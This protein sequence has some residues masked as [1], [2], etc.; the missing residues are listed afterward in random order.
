MS[1]PQ[2]SA[3]RVASSSTCHALVLILGHLQL[4]DHRFLLLFELLNPRLKVSQ[5]DYM[6]VHFVGSSLLILDVFDSRS[7]LNG[8]LGKKAHT[9]RVF[10][11]LHPMRL[12]RVFQLSSHSLH[13]LL[14]FFHLLGILQLFVKCTLSGRHLALLVGDI[15]GQDRY[16]LFIRSHS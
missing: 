8:L 10:N 3:R 7:N 9:V 5:P 16:S 1:Q 15:V 13:K 2:R 12:Q 11:L 14:F 4:L 6:L